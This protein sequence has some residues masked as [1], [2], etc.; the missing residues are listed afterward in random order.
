MSKQTHKTSGSNKHLKQTPCFTTLFGSFLFILEVNSGQ[1]QKGCLEGLFCQ[2]C[3][4]TKGQTRKHF[5]MSFN[6]T[7]SEKH[8][9]LFVKNFCCHPL[10]RGYE[11][12]KCPTT[13][14]LKPE[15]E[16]GFHM[17]VSE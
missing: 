3:D 4:K 2:H 8:T 11:D 12:L 5:S 15:V 17:D 1:K 10:L 16:K 6:F 9:W 13:R 14:T 7:K